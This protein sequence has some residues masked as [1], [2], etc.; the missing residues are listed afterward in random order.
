MWAIKGTA[1]ILPIYTSRERLN[2]IGA[3]DPVNDQGFFAYIK[4]LN[5]KNFEGFLRALLKKYLKPRKFY[6]I[7]DNA[8]AHHAKSLK[9][10]LKMHEDKL[11]LI[12]LPPYSPDLNEIEELWRE[13]KRE[14]VY[15]TFYSTF[16]EFKE[17]L[18]RALR[19]SSDS[20]GKIKNLCN[21]EKCI[22]AEA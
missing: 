20:N 6:L 2:V 14:V 10:F 13:I 22:K 15:N 1:P 8:R 7:L 19:R 9:R 21:F 5:A 18:T 12:F 11:E 3:F 16:R 4:S 17:A